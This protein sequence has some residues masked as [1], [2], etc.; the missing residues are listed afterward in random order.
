MRIARL[1]AVA[2]IFAL[3]GCGSPRSPLL[4]GGQDPVRGG[5]AGFATYSPPVAL[6][7]CLRAQRIAAVRADRSTVA[8]LPLS[9]RL[10]VRFAALD[11][12]AQ[13]EQARGVAEGAELIGPALLFV[14]SAPDPRI[15]QV[16]ACLGQR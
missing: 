15:A 12:S 16:E 7:N 2:A 4:S 14:G 8:V 3:A 1:A 13:A 11:E 6:L 10:R 9:S 5:A